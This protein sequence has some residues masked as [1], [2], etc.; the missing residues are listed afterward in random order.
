LFGVVVHF[1]HSTHGGHYQAYVKGE[2]G[3]WYECDDEC[4]RKITPE[5]V[6]EQ[7]GYLL[8]YKKRVTPEQIEKLKT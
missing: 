8:F 1:G 7:E 3:P 4:I 5:T 6:M 2:N